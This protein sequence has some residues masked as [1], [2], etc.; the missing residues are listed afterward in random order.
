MGSVVSDSCQSSCESSGSL[1][2]LDDGLC[3][4][5]MVLDVVCVKVKM[6]YQEDLEALSSNQV[7]RVIMKEGCFADG[8]AGSYVKQAVEPPNPNAK[9]HQIFNLNQVAVEIRSV[10]DPYTVFQSIDKDESTD[11][12]IFLLASN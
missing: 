10:R 9:T 5:L 3:Y 12:S 6:K 8:E 11:M 7:S 2:N 4:D 1:F